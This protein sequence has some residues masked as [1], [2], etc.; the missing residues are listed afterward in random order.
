MD[1]LQKMLIQNCDILHISNFDDRPSKIFQGLEHCRSSVIIGRK[2]PNQKIHIYT[3]KYSRWY[4]GERDK[5]FSNLSFVE[6]TQFI[7]KGVIP[8]IGTKLEVNL[9]LKLRKHPR[10]SRHLLN[11]SKLNSELNDNVVF[12]HNAPQYWIRAMT[13]VPEFKGKGKNRSSHVKTL[14]VIDPK[15]RNQII[16]VL[17]STLFYWFFVITSNGRDLTAEI[18]EN[19]NIMLNTGGTG[20]VCPNRQTI[21]PAKRITRLLRNILFTTKYKK[22]LLKPVGGSGRNLW[23]KLIPPV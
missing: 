18:I 17:N 19:F 8:K 14:F 9:L 3:T 2:N 7:S 20:T 10:L 21:P 4:S 6:C 22:I 12:Y 5:L 15:R 23:I 13:F 1:P 16:S 11:G